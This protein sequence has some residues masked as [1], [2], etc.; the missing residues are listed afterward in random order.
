MCVILDNPIFKLGKTHVW[1]STH[2]F[3]TGIPVI[4]VTSYNAHIQKLPCS[5]IEGR[6]F[7]DRMMK[8]QP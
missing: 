4:R 3:F 7:K 6:G 8:N 5:D 1:V 2:L